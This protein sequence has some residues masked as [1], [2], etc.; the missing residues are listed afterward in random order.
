[1]PPLPET[2]LVE[3]P[4]PLKGVKNIY[5]PFQNIMF[6]LSLMS[7]AKAIDLVPRPDN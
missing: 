7:L 6:N 5:F 1:M 4:T 3:Y 2:S